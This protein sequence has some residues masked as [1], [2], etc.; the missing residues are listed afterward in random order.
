MVVGHDELDA[1]KPAS[2]QTLQ[3]VPPIDLGFA[4]GHRATQH[5]AL[6]GSVDADGDQYGAI[7]DAAFQTHL[8]APAA[9]YAA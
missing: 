7:M 3:E 1:M 9:A 6:A 2:K 8:L 4:R 5:P